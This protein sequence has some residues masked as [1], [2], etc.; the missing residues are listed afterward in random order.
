MEYRRLLRPLPLFLIVLFA[1]VAVGDLVQKALEEPL[2]L[3]KIVGSAVPRFEASEPV[4]DFRPDHADSSVE[5]LP[6][7]DLARDQWSVLERRGVWAR[8]AAARLRLELAVGGHRVLILECLP[9]GGKRPVRTVRLTINGIDCGEVMLAPEWRR[10]R[11]NLPKGT[12]R[13]GFNGIALEFPDRAEATRPRRAL[14]IRRFGLFLDE[15][16]GAGALDAVRPVSVDVAAGRV[17]VR[18]SGTLEMP[19]VLD[20]RTDALQMRYRCSSGVGCA[21]VAVVQPSEGNAGIGDIVK[22]PLS[23][24][25]EA[26]GRIRIP[27][28]GRRGDYVLRIHADLDPPD[29]RLVISS[30]QLV[31][32][33]DPTRRPWAANQ[34]RN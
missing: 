1:A 3:P 8:G 26:S 29:S 9:A 15:S 16:I 34:P 6:I 28:H 5:T 14:L 7:P 11:F 2:P 20:D 18:R 24:D 10:Y 23:A 21:E 17:T 31:E 22:A 4:I 32:E 33:G 19:L 12:V 13:P 25:R 27:L 30:L